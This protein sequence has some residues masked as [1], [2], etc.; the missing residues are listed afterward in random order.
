MSRRD[1]AKPTGAPPVSASRPVQDHPKLRPRPR[2]FKSL[3]IAYAIWIIALLVLYFTT[4]Y[5][6]RHPSSATQPQILQIPGASH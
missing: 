4:V 1:S 2:L 5:P 3:C 6:L